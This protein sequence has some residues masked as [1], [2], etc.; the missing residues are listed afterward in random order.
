MDHITP[1]DPG[2][3]ATTEAMS[4]AATLAPVTGS[5][6]GSLHCTWS[7][8]EWTTQMRCW[9]AYTTHNTPM[10]SSAMTAAVVPVGMIVSGKFGSRVKRPSSAS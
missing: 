5:G 1:I 2:P 4:S 7:A 8:I 6:V 10:E 9:A 3:K